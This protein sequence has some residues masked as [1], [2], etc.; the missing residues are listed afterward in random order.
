MARPIDGVP[1]RA[2]KALVGTIVHLRFRGKIA[3]TVCKARMIVW[4]GGVLDYVSTARML[5]GWKDRATAM[6][7]E[8][9]YQFYI[10]VSRWKSPRAT[11]R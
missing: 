6:T 5:R 4:A 9:Q 11:C 1:G 3:A 7:K 10:F 8:H 2:G